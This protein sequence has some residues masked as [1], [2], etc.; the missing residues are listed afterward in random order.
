MGKAERKRTESLT[1]QNTN[2]AVGEGEGTQKD[3]WGEVAKTRPQLGTSYEASSNFYGSSMGGVGAFDPETYNKVSSQNERNIETGGFN[4]EAL[5]TVR[6]HIASNLQGGGYTAEEL[7]SLKGG[8]IDPTQAGVVRGG[9]RNLIDTGGISDETAGA[10]QR[11]AAGTTA[12]IYSTLGSKLTKSQATS[13]FGGAGGETAQLA[14]QASQAGAEATTDVNARVGQLRQQGTIA[15]L[16]GL[17]QF[18]LGSA[19]AQRSALRGVS[20]GRIASTGQEARLAE[21][22]AQGRISASRASQ[23]LATGAAEQRI[24]AAGGMAELYRQD[25]QYVTSLVDQILKSQ[26]TTG[27]LTTQQAQIMEELSRQPGLFDTILKTIGT[28][29]GAAAG[30]MGGLGSM[31]G[32]RR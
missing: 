9:Y 5:S 20:E 4:P 28:V 29:G 6:G 12:G 16:G 25:Q 31:S 27:Q 13:G 21:S 7:E 10:M 17:S 8:A 23:E 11:K 1:S 32:P 14:R 24:R 3:I 15:G 2:R 30:V 26:A 19:E 22:E 18:E